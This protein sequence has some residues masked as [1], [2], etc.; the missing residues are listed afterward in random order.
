[1]TDP[2]LRIA[3]IIGSTGPAAVGRAVGQWA[4]DMARDRTDAVFELLEI[5]DYNLPL[6]D[7]PQ[8]ASTLNP[9][10]PILDQYTREHTRAWSE[11]VATFDGYVFVTPEYNHSISGALKNAIDFLFH[12]WGN[13]AAGFIGCG[14]TN[15]AR[16]IES[17]RLVMSAV[18]VATVRPTVGLSLFTDF[19]NGT[20]FRPAAIQEQFVATLFEHVVAWSGALRPLRAPKTGP[21]AQTNE[22]HVAAPRG[23]LR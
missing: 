1:M 7:E 23:P 9:G 17:L 15:G 3:I 22:S 6:L 2:A 16:A 18:H 5:E 20:A 12:E 11:V 10:L 14:A 8:P 21:T 13:K 4:Y 19:E